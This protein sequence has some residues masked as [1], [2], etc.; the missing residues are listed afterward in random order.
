[1]LDKYLQMFGGVQTDK[2]RDRYPE[3]TCHRAPHEPF[4]ASFFIGPHRPRPDHRKPHRT[5][6]RTCRHIHHLLGGHHATWIQDALILEDGAY[7]PS[8]SIKI[9]NTI[10][11][12]LRTLQLHLLG[13]RF[14]F[15]RNLLT[16]HRNFQ[17]SGTLSTSVTILPVWHS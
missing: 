14:L 3:F 7:W 15:S 13:Q 10:P 16:A 1:M 8:V 9:E 4:F 11:L 5:L 17:K 6:L 2:S 12:Y